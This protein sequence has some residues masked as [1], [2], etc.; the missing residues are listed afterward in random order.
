MMQ[1]THIMQEIIIKVKLV[2][3]N[4][5]F[6]K[7]QRFNRS[8]AISSDTL[9]IYL[10]LFVIFQIICKNIFK[11]TNIMYECSI[12]IREQSS[13]LLIFYNMNFYLLRAN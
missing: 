2:L 4:L 7:K 11:T 5:L 13:S 9:L 12:L 3:S 8:L 1:F 6:K 10:F